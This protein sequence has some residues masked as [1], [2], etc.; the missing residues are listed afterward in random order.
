MVHLVHAH[1]ADLCATVHWSWQQSYHDVAPQYGQ[2]LAM[3]FR[4]GREQGA[5]PTGTSLDDDG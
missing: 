2:Q 5:A 4:E 3:V 1:V